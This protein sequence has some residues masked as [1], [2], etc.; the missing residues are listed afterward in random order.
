M[1]D[2]PDVSY[3]PTEEQELIASTA[4]QFVEDRIG[5]DK[6][7]ESMM[8]DDGFDP[9][10]WKEMAE[11]GWTGLGIGEE[12]GGS[13]L[14]PVDMGVLL[15][16]MGRLVT[17]GPFFASAVL[18]TTT[19]QELASADQRA[20]LLPALA[21]GETIATVAVFE[22]ARDWSLEQPKTEAKRSAGGWVLEGNKRAVLNG[23]DAGLLLVTAATE[24]GVGVFV[25]DA[26]ADGVAVTPES[27][28]DPTRRQASVTFDGVSLSDDA[29][30]G[31]GDAGPG[32]G[33]V[34][35]LATTAMAAEQVGGAQRCLELSVDYA[36]SRYQF[37]RPIGSYQAIKHRCANMLMK[38]EHARSAAYHA[39]RVTDV[40][41][42][43]AIAAPLAGSVA[44][45]AYVWV[46]GE[47]IQV[48]GGI[49][50]TWE[51]D[52]HIY[53]KRAKAS[54]LLL[55][56]PRHQRSLMGSAIGI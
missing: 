48:H 27:V 47:T 54:S 50:F 35:A 34:L 4:R 17:P 39:A 45:E 20:E 11:M 22:S 23:A 38:V 29:R 3:A 5:L 43:F 25:V 24:D 14:S 28:L 19:I 13:G 53:L 32:L 26:R 40:P 30:L 16:E 42:E 33:H 1:A 41:D 36:K 55:G 6:V 37:G 12:H 2:T 15:E 9:V 8:S 18:A 46:A 56:G 52:A 51:H 10:L 21:S 44:S 49:G 7:R 31:E